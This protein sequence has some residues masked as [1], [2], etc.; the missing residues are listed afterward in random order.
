MCDYLVEECFELVEAIRQND[1]SE[2]AEELGC[3]LPAAL[4][5]PLP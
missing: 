5:W 4:H 3:A 2:I 1:R